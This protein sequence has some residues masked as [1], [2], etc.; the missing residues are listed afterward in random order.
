M[1]IHDLYSGKWDC[2]EYSGSPR[3]SL[4]LATTP[5]SG[6]TYCAIKL[7]Q[8]GCLGA[9]LEYLNFRTTGWLC[10]RLGFSVG[11]DR[12]LESSDVLPYWKK[13]Q[14][15]RTSRN[16]A[17]SLKMFPAIYREIAQRYPQLLARLGT[18][19]V[20]YLYRDDLVGQAISYARAQQSGA[21]FAD[22]SE[23]SG[24]SYDFA[25]IEKCRSSILGQQLFWKNLFAK[26]STRPFMLKYEDVLASPAS[27]VQGLRDELGIPSVDCEP[28]DVP[29]VRPQADEVSQAWRARFLEEERQQ[30]SGAPRSRVE[31]AQ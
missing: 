13:I 22:A 19:H 7:W 11:E 8:T 23:S 20:V 12:F 3:F 6:S 27:A 10:R 25:L 28:L 14:A 5:R 26:T 31:V 1:L 21:W 16:G 30:G 2:P 17:F 15:L 4:M 9:P 29:E 24:P 18:T